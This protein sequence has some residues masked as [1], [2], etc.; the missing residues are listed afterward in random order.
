MGYVDH[1]FHGVFVAVVDIAC[2]YNTLPYF[3]YSRHW[4]TIHIVRKTLEIGWSFLEV[5]YDYEKLLNVL[6]EGF[7]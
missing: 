2:F 3:Y 4:A 5:M 1:F 6:M 7:L